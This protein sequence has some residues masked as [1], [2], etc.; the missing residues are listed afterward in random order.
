L[1]TLKPYVLS[2]RA[3]ILDAR[4]RCLLLRRPDG[5]GRFPGKWEFPGGK[6]DP[7]ETVDA[8]LA[9]EVREETGCSVEIEGMAG[10]VESELPK[11]RIVH[12]V[13]R[14][15]ITSGEIRLSEEHQAFQWTP[16]P[17]L[18]ETAM[19]EHLLRF[20]QGYLMQGGIR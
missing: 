12:L 3:L 19:P 5:D 11:W 10:F 2:V 15:R 6:L 18:T 8:A 9:R 4:G 16:L 7:C 13:F 1:S 20:V 17:D 14:A